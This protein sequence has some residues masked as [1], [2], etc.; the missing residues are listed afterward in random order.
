MPTAKASKERQVALSGSE[1]LT[2]ADHG[3]HV[4][5]I[6]DGQNFSDCDA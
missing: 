3:T 4:V 5:V 1:V 6:C 2:M